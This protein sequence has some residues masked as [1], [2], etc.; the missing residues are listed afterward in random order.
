MS[1]EKSQNGIS[2]IIPAYNE[3]KTILSVINDLQSFFQQQ[4][5]KYEIIVINDSSSDKTAELVKSQPQIKLISHPYNKGYG[6]SL[7]TGVKNALYDWV[8]FFDSDG[9]HESKSLPALLEKIGQYD[10]VVG[11]R[12]K[13]KGPAFRRPGKKIL[14][15]IAKILVAKEIPDI[16]SGLRLIKKDLFN[17]FTHILPNSFSLSTTITLAFFKEGLNVAYVP[18]EIKKR[19]TSSKSSVRILRDGIQ[20][21]LLIL[22]VIMLFNP[23]KIFIP[24]S[25]FLFI[26]G[27]IFSLYGVLLFGRMPNSG[28]LILVTSVILFF[29]GL[30]AD[31]LSALR[32]ER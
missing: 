14:N 32:R 26:F 18:I 19:D 21:I 31:Q 7:K 22:R 8:L 5:Y 1:L 30:L 25:V 27:V 28:V 17:K 9:Q 2:I 12:S 16:N 23:L 20:A 6:A 10:M 29:N 4:S 3:E 13:Y 11:A 24:V 15:W